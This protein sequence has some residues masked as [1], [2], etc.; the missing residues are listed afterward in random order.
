MCGRN[1]NIDVVKDKSASRDNDLKK[2]F[3][4]TKTLPKHK[5]RWSN[6]YYTNN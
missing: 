3:I 4:Y 5:N 6:K 2:R 1:V